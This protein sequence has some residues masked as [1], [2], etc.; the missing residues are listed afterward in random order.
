MDARARERR[1]RRG[2]RGVQVRLAPG[3]RAHVL[4]PE[5]WRLDKRGPRGDPQSSPP[6]LLHLIRSTLWAADLDVPGPPLTAPLAAEVAT[7]R[8]AL[9]GG[10]GAG[11]GGGRPGGGG[12]RTVGLHLRPAFRKRADRRLSLAAGPV[13]RRSRPRAGG[14]RSSKGRRPFRQVLTSVASEETLIACG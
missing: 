3:P 4:R 9:G 12:I 8:R 1:L 6:P 5:P 11:R 13:R 2:R 14:G 10:G 7:A